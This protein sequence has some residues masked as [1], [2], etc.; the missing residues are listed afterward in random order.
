[1]FA[2]RQVSLPAAQL[3]VFAVGRRGADAALGLN[4]Q[5]IGA[6]R[7]FQ[8]GEHLADALALLA[9]A[10]QKEGD[11][12]A[13]AHGDARQLAGTERLAIERVQPQK[14]RRRIRTAAPKPGL[15]GNALGNLDARA[16]G[17]LCGLKK[18]LRRQKGAVLLL[19]HA[20][21]MHAERIRRLYAERIAK[22]DA[23]HD[24]GKGV[25]A[26]FQRPGNFQI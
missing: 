10:F 20:R 1:M 7:V 25:V 12:C 26:V 15:G 17:Q 8:R 6:K 2:E 18:E 4:D 16:A 21:A 3:V 13:N 9:S 14:S 11:V 5:I 22:R 23:L 24:H 19:G